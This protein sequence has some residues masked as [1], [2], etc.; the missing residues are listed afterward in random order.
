M[1][2][3]GLSPRE[4]LERKKARLLDEAAAQEAAAAQAKAAAAA[5]DSDLAV[6]ERL[7]SKHGLALIPAAEAGSPA[8]YG[9]DGSLIGLSAAYKTHPDSAYAKVRHVS[10]KYYDGLIKRI[11]RDCPA[12]RVSDLNR[13]RLQE[14]YRRWAES[15]AS[16]AHGLV[17]MLR[18]LATFGHTVL[19]DGDCT[20]LR[21]ELHML[22]VP[23]GTKAPRPSVT[24]EQAWKIIGAAHDI[25]WHSIALAQA[26][27]FGCKLSQ[28][29]VIGEWV[30]L[31]EPGVSEVIH[32]DQKWLRGLRWEEIDRNLV[33]RHTTSLGKNVEVDL[34]SIPM[35]MEE[36]RRFAGVTGGER[37]TRRHL[38]TNGP[39][40]IADRSRLPDHIRLPFFNGVFRHNVKPLVEAACAPNPVT[41]AAENTGVRETDTREE[42]VG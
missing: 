41:P 17:G 21:M 36:L 40:I 27:Q 26:F 34:K 14:L 15:G 29:D 37:L 13:E 38:P 35:V 6:L 22:K 32:R 11:E 4:L 16:I 1:H 23:V 10:R 31:S 42:N 3:D 24:E 2:S 25:G 33:L 19:K 9:F 5:I 7:A 18:G 28:K 12:V 39:T 30:P 8:S 20:K